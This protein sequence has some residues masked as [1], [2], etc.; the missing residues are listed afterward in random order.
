MASSRSQR[1][2]PLAPLAALLLLV[3]GRGCSA[4]TEVILKDKCTADAVVSGRTMSFP[5]SLTPAVS[6]AAAGAKLT[7]LPIAP[8]RDSTFGVTVTVKI[9]FVCIT[10]ARY[11]LGQLFPQS[12]PINGKDF[13]W[14]IDGLNA[15]GLSAAVLYQAESVGMAG[16]DAASPKRDAINFM[17]LGAFA[18]ARFDTVA[19]LRRFLRGGLQVVWSPTY[20]KFG[21]ALSQGK[22]DNPTLHVTFHD[23][24]RQH[25]AEYRRKMFANPKGV[26]PP[27]RDLGATDVVDAATTQHLFWPVP[28]DYSG[29]SRFTRLALV[30]EAALGECWRNTSALFPKLYETA[31]PDYVWKGAPASNPTLLTVLGIINTVYLPNGI[32]DSGGRGPSK[33]PEFTFKAVDLK[34]VDWAALPG[35]TAMTYL[36][37]A[38]EPWFADHS[39]E[40]K[41]GV[42]GTG[43]LKML[44]AVTPQAAEQHAPDNM[45][46]TLSTRRGA[47]A[48][49]HPARAGLV[50]RASAQQQ[51]PLLRR[52]GSALLAAGVALSLAAGPMAPPPALA[53][54]ARLADRRAEKEAA[55]AEQLQKLEYAF[56]QEQTARRAQLVGQR[57]VLENQVEQVETVLQRKLIEETA[58]EQ[59][60]ASK[61]EVQRAA[62]IAAE[63]DQV[64]AQ[65]AA[66][67]V[68][69]AKAEAQLARA[70][71]VEK[72]TEAA[73]KQQSDRERQSRSAT[74]SSAARPA[75]RLRARPRGRLTLPP[76]SEMV[77]A[78]LVALLV[79][80]ALVAGSSGAA[81]ARGLLQGVAVSAPFTDVVVAGNAPGNATA[82][83]VDAPGTHADVGGGRRLTAVVATFP[84]GSVNVSSSGVTVSAPGTTVRVANASTH[85]NVTRVSVTAS[86]GTD[87]GVHSA[88]R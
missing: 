77:P 45:R 41:R 85:G 28:G 37:P 4:C 17:N 58:N 73:E 15:K 23:A 25:H 79:A 38:P 63:A 83:S 9:P 40:F 3:A 53:A 2:P 10:H 50:V 46:A 36:A 22:A 30:K 80:A 44:A 19:P 43:S 88:G 34:R 86:P 33:M 24:T 49:A 11:E 16:Y 61:G 81:A 31:N 8:G 14:C 6:W 70:E 68:A 51:Q 60:A 7:M 39:N 75:E 20:D 21:N 71:L 55:L 29:P 47:A 48:A 54:P 13:F 72:A 67:Q 69:A 18:L 35:A 65:E 5:I 76:P 87:V 64:R 12:D 27:V 57:Q 32:D 74:T 42:W 62:R 84:G 66:L 78:R 1:R 26:A 56:E 59:A 82:V 52:A